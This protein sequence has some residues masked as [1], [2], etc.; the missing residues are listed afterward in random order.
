MSKIDLKI[1]PLTRVEGEGGVELIITN[2]KIEKL[3]LN[4][5]EAPRFFEAF[6]IGRKYSEVPDLVARICGICPIPYIYSSSRAIEKIF[7]IEIPKEIRE[8]RKIML[9]GEWISS[10]TLHAFLLHAPDFLRLNDAIELAKIEPETIRK[11]MRLKAFGNYIIEKLGGRPVHPISCRIGGF[12]RVI[13]KT[14]LKD[15]KDKCREYQEIA[16]ELLKWTFKLKIPEVKCDYEY[17]SLKDQDNEYPTIGGRIISNKGLNIVEEDFEK[18]IEEIQVPYSTSLRCKI[19]RR[20]FYIT[21]PIARYNNNYN[22]LRGEVRDIIEDNGYKA[23]LTNTY[24]SIIA[25]LA[26]I[27]HATLEIERLIDE[28]REPEK[29]YVEYKVKGGWG[30]GATEAPRGVLY[31]SYKLNDEGF[32]EKARIIAPTTQNLAH[33][34]QDIINQIPLIISKPIEEAQLIVEQIIRNYDP[35]ISC[36]VHSIKLKI[37]IN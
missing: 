2:G 25:R 17:L 26:E 18:E 23:P 36:S 11:A 34:E 24:Q 31:H 9:F 7:E 12:Y 16:K 29:P 21:G 27:F 3:E 14:E 35:C 5:F 22:T 15:I 33:I 37:K 20:G 10:H 28:Y 6:L 1:K 8:L 13:R 30:C 4:I 32:V 19:R